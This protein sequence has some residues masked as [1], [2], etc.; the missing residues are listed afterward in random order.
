M[1]WIIRSLNIPK[2][3]TALLWNINQFLSSD[4]GTVAILWAAI[5][6]IEH[7]LFSAWWLLTP[8]RI[9]MSGMHPVSSSFFFFF[10]TPRETFCR[11]IWL[12][13]ASSRYALFFNRAKVSHLT[14]ERSS[15]WGSCFGDNKVVY[16]SRSLRIV[17]VTI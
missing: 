3:D 10:R 12:F 15:N 2:L 11:V 8:F 14:L 6:P 1:S 5:R 16:S 7:M 9:C 4:C 17:L 13:L